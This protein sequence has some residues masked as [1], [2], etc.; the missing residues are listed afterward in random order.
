[1]SDAPQN[2]TDPVTAVDRRPLHMRHNVVDDQ[3]A[4]VGNKGYSNLAQALKE[5]Q[6]EY[7]EVLRDCV[8]TEPIDISTAGTTLDLKD[9]TVV[10]L[11]PGRHA[12]NQEDAGP[13]LTISAPGIRLRNGRLAVLSGATYA[14]RVREAQGHRAELELS[15]IGIAYDGTGYAVTILE[16]I[17][18]LRKARIDSAGSGVHLGSQSAHIGITGSR[19]VSSGNAAS[20]CDGRLIMD[21]SELASRNYHGIYA[22]GGLV[23]ICASVVGSYRSAAIVTR[24]PLHSGISPS[25]RI[26]EFS[27]VTAV[28]RQGLVLNGGNTTILRSLIRSLEGSAIEMGTH[29]IFAPTRLSIAEEATISSWRRDGIVHRSGELYVNN[30]HIDARYEAIRESVIE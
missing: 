10:F 5:G 23:G 27:E 20:V 18:L 29:S 15:N 2:V 12:T 13:A 21:G 25:V 24:A 14:I 4:C 9:N 1:M 11:S 8:I 17:V 3:V 16:G 7:I 22:E 19:I 26:C 28:K 6:G 30:A